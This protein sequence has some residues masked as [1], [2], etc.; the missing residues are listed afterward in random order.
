MAALTAPFGAMRNHG[1]V[2][3]IA[4][5]Q[6]RASVTYQRGSLVA[7]RRGSKLAEIPLASAKRSDLIFVGTFVGCDEFTASSSADGGGGALDANGDV[8]VVTIH[9]GSVGWFDTGSGVNA[10]TLS[11]VGLPCFAFSDN[12]LYLTDL[13]GTLSYVGLIAD[14]DAN[15]KVRVVINCLSG[16]SAIYAPSAAIGDGNNQRSVRGI[17]ASNIAS[18]AA[19]TVASNDGITYEENQRVALVNQTTV[20]QCGIYIV[21]AVASGVAPLT[22]AADMASGDVLPIGFTFEVG[23]EGTEFKNTTWKA[24]S[25]VAGGAVIGTDDPVFYPRSYRKTITLALGTYTIGAGSTATPDEPL[26]MLAGATVDH[27]LNTPNTT[28]STTEY[29]APS[30]SRTAGKAGTAAVLIRANVA[31]GTI[32]VADLSTLDVEVTNWS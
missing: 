2:D 27:S 7:C 20:A 18:L 8:Q 6:S 1:G 14:V 15:G 29:C 13:G 21:G 10:I 23:P 25:T 24:T 28:T 16:L 3:G 32:N 11:H 4:I 5:R 22:R 17:V 19:F 12:T 26:F 9:P 30:A 31:A